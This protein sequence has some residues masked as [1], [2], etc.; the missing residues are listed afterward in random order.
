MPYPTLAAGQPL[1]VGMLQGLQW[2]TVQQGSDLVV[3]NSAV[4]VNSN[5]TV[6]VV[7]NAVYRF[8]LMASYNGHAS[9]G[10]AFAWTAPVGGSVERWTW[11][12]GANATGSINDVSSMAM[13]RT[14]TATVA[15]LGAIGTTNSLAYHEEGIFNSGN[16]GSITLQFAQSTAFATASTLTSSSRLEYLRIG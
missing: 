14:A 3:T 1:T 5:L 11:G 8:R 7:A 15:Q 13:R 9:G 12:I 2:Q 16:G 10:A 6:T 4:L